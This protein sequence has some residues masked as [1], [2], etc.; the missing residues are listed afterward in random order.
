VNGGRLSDDET[1]CLGVEE[2]RAQLRAPTPDPAA[3][4]RAL[5]RIGMRYPEAVEELE[6]AWPQTAE[7]AAL[8]DAWAARHAAD[9]AE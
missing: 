7:T 1:F 4:Q 2:L 8:L 5:A 3:A 6:A 9:S